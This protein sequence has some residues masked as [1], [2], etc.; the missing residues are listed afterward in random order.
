[1][2]FLSTHMGSTPG[3]GLSGMH[4]QPFVPCFNTFMLGMSI[5]VASL[6]IDAG[7]AE[8]ALLILSASVVGGATGPTFDAVCG[9]VFAGADGTGFVWARA[10]IPTKTAM[11]PTARSR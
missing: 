6:A 4:V 5:T 10:V 11:S 1:M 3:D 7:A 8:S 9:A 2:P